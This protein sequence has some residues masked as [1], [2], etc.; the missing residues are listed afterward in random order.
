MVPV[1]LPENLA[2]HNHIAIVAICI[3]ATENKRGGKPL[4]C[5]PPEVMAMKS[6]AKACVL[7]CLIGAALA[8]A[9][10]EPQPPKPAREN[11]DSPIFG[12]TLR[13]GA[14]KL[15]QSPQPPLDFVHDVMPLV[16]KLGCNQTQCHG[17][18]GGKGELQLSLFGA[19]P[20]EDFEALIKGSKG[21]RVN[22]AEPAKSLLLLK[23]T[24]AVE[25]GGK[26]RFAVGSP[27]Y[28]LVAKWLAAG[29]PLDNPDRPK[30]VRM[31]LAP[32]EQILAKGDRRQLIVAAVF[33]DGARR[34]VTREAVFRPSDPAVATVGPGGEVHAAGP[35]E[36]VILASYLRQAGV[37]RIIV[38]Q[39]VAGPFPKFEPNNRIDELVLAKLKKLGIP[40]AELSSDE[41]FLRRAYLDTIGVLPRPDEV[42]AFLADREP[43]KR[44]RLI[45]RLL[46]RDEFAD[47]W[48]LKW[49]D[50]LRIKS[51]YPVNLW[52][53]A[54]ETYYRWI[55]QSIAANKPYDRF[56]T[57]LLTSSGSNFRDPPV[58][59]YRAMSKK[60]PQ[61][62]A[63]T[64][65]LIFLGARIGCAQC[66]G[67]PQENWDINDE[68]G[69]AAFFTQLRF[70][71]TSEWKE[72]IVFISGASPMRDPKTKQVVPPK[73][74]GDCPG[75][76]STKTGLSPPKDQDLRAVFAAWLTAADNRPFAENIVNRVW[77]WL[78]GRGIVH[79]P[80][81]LRPTNPPENPELLE[82][83][84]KELVGHRYDLKHVYRLI[85]NSRTYQLSSQANE[86]NAHDAAHFSHYQVKRLGAE[87]LLD[88]IC[89]A[90]ETG[91]T[92]SSWVPAP[93]PSRLPAGYRAAQIPDANIE[94]PILELFG[95]PP[96]DTAYES[97]RCSQS[98]LRQAL[99][100]V[101]SDHLEGK[102]AASG[103]IKRL[104]EARQSDGQIVDELVLASLSRLPSAKEKQA[105]LTYIQ[106]HKTNRLQ[107]IR[108][109]FWAVLNTKEFLFDH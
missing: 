87:Q 96:R 49:G 16:T 54:A 71:P 25:H 55:R 59:Y 37:A 26:Q 90:T 82:Y 18:A 8:A 76:R 104:L 68:L 27:E 50:L 17:A 29:A 47:F 56:V 80:D 6:V 93:P 38:P 73:F 12:P 22:T 51:E 21:R 100:F 57:E 28:R 85:L 62:I 91:E 4:L 43:R 41:E 5:R 103:R 78:L 10:A 63:E 98:S 32:G 19:A 75:F 66:H 92:Y 30:L 60:E 36:A 2:A 79:E 109:V 39:P 84:R 31:T 9:G 65:A 11:W 67:H 7:V 14:R 45:D 83:L 107:A 64:T 34:D 24:A 99:Y 108:D 15:G 69:L 44:S 70:K 3:A 102:V 52:P 106:Q 95:R 53:K 72:E 1:P 20:A 97:D 89:Q 86:A 74:L 81:D 61:T 58:N 94:S 105:F 46:E 77:F 42:R 13:V 23:A 33:A 40:P 35:G 48:A 101:N 88:A